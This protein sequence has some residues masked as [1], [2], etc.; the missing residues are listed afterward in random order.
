MH[1]ESAASLKTIQKIK[2]GNTYKNKQGYTFS[3]VYHNKVDGIEHDRKELPNIIPDSKFVYHSLKNPLFKSKRLNIESENE[4]SSIISDIHKISSP[5]ESNWIFFPGSK[6]IENRKIPVFDTLSSP[7]YF[8]SKL[9]NGKLFDNKSVLKEVTPNYDSIIKSDSGLSI[10]TASTTQKNAPQKTFHGYNFKEVKTSD[11]K[12]H[13]VVQI[14]DEGGLKENVVYNEKGIVNNSSAPNLNNGTLKNATEKI[15]VIPSNDT[16]NIKQN[17]NISSPSQIQPATITTYS[18]AVYTN[19]ANNSS[20]N[21]ETNFNMPLSTDF[22]TPEYI[23]FDFLGQ[24]NTFPFGRNNEN[25]ITNEL[26]TFDESL[27]ENAYFFMKK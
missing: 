27:N 1:P 18:E 15:N 3:E 23:L 4:D 9:S 22:A 26:N 21:E 20:P 10:T 19:S 8:N 14:F 13:G 17:A 2:T 16:K 11:G 7:S 24:L 25:F 6:L 5:F 12:T